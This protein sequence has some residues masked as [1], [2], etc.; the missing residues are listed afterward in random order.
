M[1]PPTA[2]DDPT[3]A[4]RSCPPRLL[5]LVRCQQ[6]RSPHMGPKRAMIASG[7]SLSGPHRAFCSF[8]GLERG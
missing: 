8:P 5:S 6:R 7:G 1:S 2:G 3:P 4:T